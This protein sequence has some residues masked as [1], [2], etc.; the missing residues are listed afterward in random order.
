MHFLLTDVQG[1]TA[2]HTRRILFRLVTISCLPAPN[3]II[4][5]PLSYCLGS[6]LCQE[7]KCA[8]EHSRAEGVEG[9]NNRNE[10]LAKELFNNSACLIAG[11]QSPCSLI[12]I[13]IYIFIIT[14]IVIG[15]NFHRAIFRA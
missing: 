4:E 3:N 2:T 1:A 12:N 5:T 13:R 6:I 14:L 9:P 15:L 7:K 8:Q 11:G 10:C